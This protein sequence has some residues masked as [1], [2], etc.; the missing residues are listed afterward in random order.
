MSQ[1]GEV[2]THVQFVDDTIC[3]ISA[4]IEEVVTLK[5]IPVDIDIEGELI[6]KLISWGWM[7][8]GGY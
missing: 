7:F 4:R 2:V 3:F 5:R 1:N 8:E 6:K